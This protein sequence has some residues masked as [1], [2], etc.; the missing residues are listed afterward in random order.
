MI[1]IGTDTH[2]RTH[3][4]VAVVAGTADLSG[5]LTASALPRGFAEMLAW[6]QRLD[7]ERIWAIK[8]CRHFSG[9]LERFLVG[10]TVERISRQRSM[11]S[12]PVDDV[13]PRLLY[14]QSP[15][16]H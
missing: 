1:V 15:F 11:D 2:K 12:A 7:G 14:L 16:I 3:T 5:E 9:G 6:A 8:D 13:A 10:R 4:A